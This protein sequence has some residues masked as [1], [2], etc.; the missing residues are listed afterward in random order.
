MLENVG[1]THAGKWSEH[2]QS[3]TARRVYLVIEF[4]FSE[5]KRDGVTL[6]EWASLLSEWRSA[7]ISVADAC[8]ALHLHLAEWL[9]LV[10][11]V[12]SGGRSLHGWYYVF[13]HPDSQLFPIMRNAYSLGADHVTWNRAQFCRMPDGTRVNGKRQA[14]VYL[15][16]GKAVKNG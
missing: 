9:P 15:D 13:N 1:L 8:S 4:D 7:G 12:S 16:P 3:A 2:A 5:F 14:V 6:T 10:L 11:V